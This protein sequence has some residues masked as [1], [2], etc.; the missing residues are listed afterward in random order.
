VQVAVKVTYF[1]T[2]LAKRELNL[3]ALLKH[4]NI[5]D[6]LDVREVNSRL[7][8]VLDYEKYEKTLH[9]VLHRTFCLHDVIITGIRY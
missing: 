3:L 1:D 5:V 2:L 7:T 8:L 4:P 9:D 6:I